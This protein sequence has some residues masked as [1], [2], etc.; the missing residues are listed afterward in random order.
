MEL[1]R[2]IENIEMKWK[3]NHNNNNKNIWFDEVE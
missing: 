1:E 2:R 3:K